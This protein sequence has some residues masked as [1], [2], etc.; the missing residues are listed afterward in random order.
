[1]AS[2]KKKSDN[3]AVAVA[4]AEAPKAQRAPKR[5]DADLLVFHQE[6]LERLRAEAE[7][8]VNETLPH[9]ESIVAKYTEYVQ[10]GRPSR[11]VDSGEVEAL[12][13]S[14]EDVGEAYRA[15]KKAFQI[16]AAAARKTGQMP[17]FNGKRGG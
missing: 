10:Y 4:E 6:K 11:S 14:G 1:M 2:K 13:N 15:A 9:Q 5:S 16:A 12:I 7:K 17:V 8:L 3:G